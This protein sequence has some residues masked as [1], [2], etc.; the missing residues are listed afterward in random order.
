MPTYLITFAGMIIVG[1]LVSLLVTTGTRA[2]VCGTGSGKKRPGPPYALSQD[3]A[4][5]V[6]ADAI[7]AAVI[8]H[9]R[10]IF[11][12]GKS[13]S[14]L[15]PDKRQPHCSPK[16]NRNSPWMMTILLLRHG[17]SLYGAV[18]GYDTDTLHGSLSRTF[19]CTGAR[20]VSLCHGSE[21][22]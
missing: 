5:A 15:L 11:Q 12:W 21:T 16:G 6:Y 2:C 14:V 22:H 3:L 20:L 8:R 9:I 4:V 10:E 19:R 13:L 7:I 17:H 18:A 1:A